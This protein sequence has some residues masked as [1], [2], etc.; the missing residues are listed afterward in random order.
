MKFELY[1]TS[2]RGEATVI[3]VATLDELLKLINEYGHKLI[4]N[5]RNYPLLD[6][7]YNPMVDP[8]PD[9]HYTLEVYDD[10]RE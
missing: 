5:N 10:Y 6:Y 8:L 7:Q 9:V 4:L 1:K 2:G 3:E